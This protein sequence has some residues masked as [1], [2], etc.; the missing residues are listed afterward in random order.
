M[1]LKIISIE[2]GAPA[3]ATECKSRGHSAKSQEWGC[4][5]RWVEIMRMNRNALMNEVHP[6][7]AAFTKG[8]AF[9][10]QALLCLENAERPS[11]NNQN[12]QE[13]GV[14]SNARHRKTKDCLG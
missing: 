14:P 7:N 5:R 4:Y 12:Q 9:I 11:G 13:I 3:P 6:A 10:N 1:E 2:E 8:I